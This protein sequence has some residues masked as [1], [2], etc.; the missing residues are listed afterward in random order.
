MKF[1]M[2]WQPVGLLKVMLFFFF[3]FLFFMAQV[4]YKGENSA[5]M[6]SRNIPSTSSCIRTHAN[7]LVSSLV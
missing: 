3:F 5:D 2:L 6:I 1:S 4:L 7:Q